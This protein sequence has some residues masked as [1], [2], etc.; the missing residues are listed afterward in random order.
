MSRS[1][2]PE[3]LT[4]QE[5]E[6]ATALNQLISDMRVAEGLTRESDEK[7]IIL[8]IK[9]SDIDTQDDEGLTGLH[10]AT[11]SGYLKTVKIFLQQ[12]ANPNI[13]SNNGV[14]PIH[15]AMEKN[16]TEM[17]SLIAE[18]SKKWHNSQSQA[19]EIIE[20]AKQPSTSIDPQSQSALKKNQITLV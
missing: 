18:A 1:N 15:L 13:A 3:P 6:N 4:N 2:S 7:T 11:S 9:N 5:R 8:A 10:Y 20:A 16:N 19:T 17:V 12:G 14:K